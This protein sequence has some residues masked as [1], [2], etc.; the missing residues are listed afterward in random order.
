MAVSSASGYSVFD[1]EG[2][3]YVATPSTL[4]W[5]G[6][7]AGNNWSTAGNWGGVTPAAGH[8]LRFGALAAGGHT[9][10]SNNLA[11]NS[12]FYGI[13]FD[14]AAPSYN[15]QGN[16]IDLSGDVLNQSGTNQTI[17]LNIQLVPGDGAFNTNAITFDS[18]GFK[19][20]DSG[21]ISGTGMELIKTGSG[22]LVL[23]GSNNYNGGTNVIAG[24]LMVTASDGLLDGS[25][26]YV[27]AGAAT[28]FGTLEP[29][30]SSPAA[31]SAPSAV[32]EPSTWA[33]L[34]VGLGVAAAWRGSSPLRVIFSSNC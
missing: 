4:Y 12:L 24:K 26:L 2:Y 31:A 34:V 25:N 19:M 14:T 30:E 13:F 16:A 32:P 21:S 8:W 17:G 6:G 1:V 33:L 15:L 10:N 18:G 29:A 7:G 3:T 22:T 9:A 23:S 27:G 11:A 28:A 20:T 5:N